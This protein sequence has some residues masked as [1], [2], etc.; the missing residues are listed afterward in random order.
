M[1][2]RSI[3]LTLIALSIAATG[4]L[5]AILLSEQLRVGSFVEPM[6]PAQIV[7]IGGQSYRYTFTP[8][9]PGMVLRNDS[10]KKPTVSTLSITENGLPLGPAHSIHAEIARLGA[11]RFSHW[12]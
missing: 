5:A 4:L 1:Y 10:N 6:D 8:P 11:G 3:R 12:G 2:L 7:S 9:I